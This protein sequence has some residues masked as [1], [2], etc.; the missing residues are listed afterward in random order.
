MKNN[1]NI[2]LLTKEFLIENYTNKNLS[3]NRIAKLLFLSDG[4]IRDK[5]V[6]FGIP[7]RGVG[8]LKEGPGHYERTQ[9]MVKSRRGNGKF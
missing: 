9:L 6:E 4:L 8:V 2:G 7:R 5:L 1:P 3:I